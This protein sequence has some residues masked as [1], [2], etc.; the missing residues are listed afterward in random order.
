MRKDA[1]TTC[2]QSRIVVTANAD[3]RGNIQAFSGYL[4]IAMNKGV[5]SVKIVKA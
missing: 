4:S 1:S 3:N 5:K 2:R